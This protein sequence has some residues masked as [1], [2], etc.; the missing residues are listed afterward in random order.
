MADNAKSETP[1]VKCL[2]EESDKGTE[3]MLP[4]L[5]QDDTSCESGCSCNNYNQQLGEPLAGV[6]YN[7][8]TNA[9][10]STVDK[11]KGLP[12]LLS[13]LHCDETG[14]TTSRHNNMEQK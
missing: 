7:E 5:G 2:E 12:L 13:I 8:K 10:G 4:L 14:S 3:N 9:T 1:R 6:C 11:A